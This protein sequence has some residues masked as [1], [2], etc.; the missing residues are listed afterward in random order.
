MFGFDK[1]IKLHASVGSRTFP[2][3]FL[4]YGGASQAGRWM[5]QLTGSGCS[6]VSSWS[7]LG[8]L[9]AAL[10]ARIT[11][12]DLAVDFLDGHIGV[13]DAVAM[14][15]AGRF[16]S[17]GRPPTTTCAGDWIDREKGRTLYVGSAANGKLLRVYEKGKQGGD[18][19]SEWVRFEVQFGNRDR[20]IPFRALTERDLFFCGAYPAL[21]E[22][23]E[24]ASE[25]ILT[26]QT[27]G[28]VGIGH[29]MFHLRRSYG[30]LV[31]TLTECFQA[32]AADL[33]Q[34]FRVVGTPRR[35][36]PDV[37]ASQLTWAQ[38]L[39]HIQR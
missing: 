29:L 21:A 37:L 31:S 19:S 12:L 3:G 18:L 39:A 1:G 6:V 26:S 15:K 17:G 34:E 36:R 28:R 25:K 4:C 16:T 10:D 35:L 32:Q 20:V 23:L 7:R 2:I 5:L 30:K 22:M 24:H 27:A 14:H 11:R 8:K 9:L 33:V 38:L 13:D